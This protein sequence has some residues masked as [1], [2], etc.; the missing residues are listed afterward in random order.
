MHRIGI[1]GLGI[2]GQRMLNSLASDKRFQ[3]VAVYDVDEGS[4]KAIHDQEPDIS[5][6]TSA[7]ELISRSDIDLVYIATPPLSHVGYAMKCLEAQKPVLCE[8][9]LSTSIDQSRA[10]VSKAEATG[11]PNAVN[12][13][14]ATSLPVEM[15]EEAIHSGTM[16]DLVKVEI[17]CHFSQWPRAWQKAGQWLSE[18]VEGGFIREVASHFIYLT[19]RLLG[20]VKVRSSQVHYSEKDRK[21]SED[22]VMATLQ[23]ETIP[24]K[25]FGGVGGA[26]PDLVEYTLYG[27]NVS[28]RLSNWQSLERGTSNGWE[29][30]EVTPSRTAHMTALS[31]MIEKKPHHLANFSIGLRVQ[32]V[33]ESNIENG[34]A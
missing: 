14:F 15:M 12:F 18:R 2:M 25:L 34:S 3:V 5:M 4:A 9:P 1:I 33:I 22:Y 32:E 7:D 24:I 16:G 23:S 31:N 26:A 27:S 11:L 21:A 10:L 28:Y 8:K 30:I 20:T 29:P 17:R 13:P 6:A 19:E